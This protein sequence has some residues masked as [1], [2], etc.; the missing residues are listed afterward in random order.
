MPKIYDEEMSA[1]PSYVRAELEAEERRRRLSE[2]MVRR[3]AELGAPRITGS[4]GQLREFQMPD[5]TRRTYTEAG[6]LTSIELSPF[7]QNEYSPQDQRQ[8]EKLYQT[9]SKAALNPD[10]TED[11]RQS[12]FDK[13]DAD[14]S[15][16]PRL[17]P[18]MR[19][20][21]PQETFEQSIV[22]DPV[23]GVRGFF[24]PKSGKFNAM[25][26]DL[27]QEHQKLWWSRYDKNVTAL[28][29]TNTDM[30][31][32]Q[33]MS[34]E[35]LMSKAKMLTDTEVGS[36]GMAETVGTPEDDISR[37][38]GLKRGEGT[39]TVDGRT[40]KVS[41]GEIEQVP[42]E[43]SQYFQGVGQQAGQFA[44]PGQMVR[45]ISPSGDLGLI[46]REDVNEA[47]EAGYKLAG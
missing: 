44:E 35:E 42:D 4:E 23:T 13:I 1:M 30:M 31:G 40:A 9:R 17:N 32:K 21:T 43:L 34:D 8:L 37:Q 7:Y 45:V 11:E 29:S 26:A 27:N 47:L 36:L 38:F 22:T 39:V 19:Q 2:E 3:E 41:G 18:M 12:F 5:M 14:I 6:D 16:V 28:R 46:P 24:D 10:L 33:T 25:N 20:P 15:K